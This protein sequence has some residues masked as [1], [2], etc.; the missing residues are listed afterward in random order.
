MTLYVVSGY[1][2]T[3]T[4]MM[5]SALEA[6]G[7]EA[8]YQQSRDVMKNRYADDRYDPN[9]GGLY[10]LERHDYKQSDFPCQFEGKLIKALNMGVV[11]MNVMPDVKVVFMR[12]DPEEIR[13]SFD[14]FFNKQLGAIANL[15]QRMQRIIE[16][17]A[18]RKDVS[19][20][21]VF[22]YREVVNNPQSHFRILQQA[23]WPIEVGQAAA[24]VDPQYCRFRL[25]DLTV[26]VV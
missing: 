20:L 2:R 1:M 22:W 12:R 14:A 25:E 16:R 4:S 21:N 5:M 18:N 17:I 24:V 15:D 7:L 19:S 23:G 10:E 11:T 26:G 13:Q 8:C 3:G 9:I 6:G